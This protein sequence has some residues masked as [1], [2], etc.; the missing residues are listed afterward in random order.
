MT[1]SSSGSRRPCQARSAIALALV[2]ASLGLLSEADAQVFLRGRVDAVDGEVSKVTVEGVEITVAGSNDPTTLRVKLIGWDR[3][4]E[5]RGVRAASADP[6]L[7][8]AD[9][10]WR[11]R[12]R[13]ERG[14]IA[15]AQPLFEGLYEKQ[16]GLAGPSGIV[17][18]EGVL[19]CRLAEGRATG[20][21]WPW[22]DWMTV[23]NGAG[24]K[25]RDGWWA[26][27]SA[28]GVSAVSA[29]IDPAL[30]LSPRLPPVFSTSL[31]GASLKALSESDQWKRYEAADD[32]TRDTAAIY[33][34]VARW[35]VAPNPAKGADLPTLAGGDDVLI[36]LTDL[37]KARCGTAEERVPAR[38]RLKKRID[39]L[40]F[41]ATTDALAEPG[42]NQPGGAQGVLDVTP[43]ARWVEAWC[44]AAIGRSLIRE[45]GL[46]EKRLGVVE[47]LHVPARFADA[48]PELAAMMLKEGAEVLESIGDAAGARRLRAELAAFTG[49]V[50]DTESTEPGNDEAGSSG[51]KG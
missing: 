2:F 50:P 23:W 38:A 13:L 33:R 30:G 39:G 20:A 14:D 4:R 41:A 3:V 28:T 47:M 49:D 17:L 18:A 11:A 24:R 48:T 45:E 19:R 27:A 46:T 10:L 43:T 31:Q 40:A 16:R 25:G 8:M 32:F 9:S 15:L 37:A 12:M 44:R 6:F 36:M 26:G 21:V 1:Q 42:T 35:E 22:L 5:V 29:V 34:A 7:P 51:E